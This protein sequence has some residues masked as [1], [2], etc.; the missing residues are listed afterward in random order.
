MEVVIAAAN[1]RLRQIDL[2][3]YREGEKGEASRGKTLRK[4]KAKEEEMRK[5]VGPPKD[6]GRDRRPERATVDTVY[7]GEWAPKGEKA[8]MH[9]PVD[10]RAKRRR[11][12][13]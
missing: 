7:F 11:R 8:G 10:T 6:K 9:R 13:R 4:E 3:P 5:V 2:L 12:R 1:P